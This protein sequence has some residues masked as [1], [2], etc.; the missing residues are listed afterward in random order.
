MI[1]YINEYT[2][3]SVRFKKFKFYVNYDSNT[4]L[5]NIDI[6]SKCIKIN[7][8]AD[9]SLL[10][11]FKI[12][13]ADEYTENLC[14]I[15][16][17]FKYSP[18]L[19]KLI[20]DDELESIEIEKIFDDQCF[21]ETKFSNFIELNNGLSFPINTLTFTMKDK[22]ILIDNI[23]EQFLKIEKILKWNLGG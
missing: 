13:N 2:I 7:K 5:G 21:D 18:I 23:F 12:S 9:H 10:K 3:Y 4:F 11:K 8:E 17:L 20:D 6:K 15:K 22:K 19:S 1:V 14:Y 16:F